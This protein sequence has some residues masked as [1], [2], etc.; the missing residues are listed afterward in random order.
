MK[1]LLPVIT[2]L[3]V[4]GMLTACGS[5]DDAVSVTNAETTAVETTTAA[6]T[7]AP[8]EAVPEEPTE[9]QTES[10]TEAV[11]EE[12]SAT[13][14]AETTAVQ[15]TSVTENTTTAPVE[16]VTTVT[17][18]E[19]EA[20]EPASEEEIVIDNSAEEMT[21]NSKFADMDEFLTA[22]IFMLEGKTVTADKALSADIFS[23]LKGN[24]YF[25]TSDFDG[26]SPFKLAKKGD[27]IMTSVEADGKENKT[28]IRD[29]KAFTF[30]HEN[31]VALFIPADKE[32]VSQYKP[33]NMGIIPENVSKESFVIADV[34]IGGKAYKF[35]YGT[36]SDWA[37]LYDASGKLYASVKSGDSLDCV[38]CKFS[39][40]SKIPSG[41]FDIP[42]DYFQLDLAE[43]MQNAPPPEETE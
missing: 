21:V 29:S 43:M 18:T 12:T 19:T 8:S 30:D 9:M 23:T 1:K 31:K 36:T 14:V 35:E 39:V 25:E 37:M 6:E 20:E 11:A 28:V 41:T 32:L 24:F 17:T 10:E 26:G 27:M 5:N 15:E 3:A 38:L 34:T 22:D 33:E 7:T 13:A 4:C 42:E 40:T 2:A 16:T